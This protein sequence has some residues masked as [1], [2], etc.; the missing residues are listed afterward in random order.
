[1]N[2]IIL[3]DK[4]PNVVAAWKKEFKGYNNVEIKQEIFENIRC[5]QIVTAGNSYGWMT[6]GIDLVCRNYYG[7]EIQDIVQEVIIANYGG[8][9]PVGE[10]I[11]IFDN[12]EH[13][14]D[15]IYAPTIP[16]PPYKATA[17]EMYKVFLSIL[18]GFW[19][20]GDIACCGLGTGC[21]CVEPIDA[22]RAMRLAYDEACRLLEINDKEVELVLD[23]EVCEEPL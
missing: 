4:D 6:G 8:R 12:R 5:Q 1:M 15:L 17:F 9:L 14:P 18:V 2:K 20:D 23:G 21:A 3:F 11:K 13:K 19:K 22:A 10:C 7:Q 16:F